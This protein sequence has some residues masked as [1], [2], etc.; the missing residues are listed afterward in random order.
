MFR[1]ASLAVALLAAT[2]FP[3]FAWTYTGGD[4]TEV[5]LDETPVRIIASQDAAAGLIPL[6]IR[7]VGI[8]A[9]SAIA[10]AKALQGLDLTGIEIISQTWGEVDIEKAAALEPDL[11]V[12]EYW[13]LETTWSGGAE[14]FNALSPVAPIT[15]PEQGASILTLIEDYEALAQSLGANL[16]DPAIAEDKAAFAT[17]LADFKAA[18]AA[19]PDLTAL[20]V[21]AGPDALYVA[22]TAGASEL[23]DFASWGLKL[24][25]PEVADDRGYWETLSWEKA[26]KYQ[27]DLIL[28]DNRSADT[29]ETAKA[30]PTWTLMKAAEAGQVTDW[31]AFWLRNY[32]AY[33]A[34]LA[35]LTAAINAADASVAP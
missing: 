13:P 29:M 1:A 24:I 30:Q 19:K 10:D 4:G 8:Y 15:G 31:P 32:H 34:E 6:G 17:A 5:T 35:K 3:A 11:I 25:D 12:A 20:A 27:P 23:M 28:V 16:S 21:W 2:A 9:D 26:D 33:S 7:P 22:A 18:T 14:V